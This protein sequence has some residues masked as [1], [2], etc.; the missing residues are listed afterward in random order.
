MPGCRWNSDFTVEH[1]AAGGRDEQ[2]CSA[3]GV[4]GVV[5]VNL[6]NARSSSFDFFL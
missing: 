2:E 3:G 1:V 4:K 5:T 6:M